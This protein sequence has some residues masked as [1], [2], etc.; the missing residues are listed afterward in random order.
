LLHVTATFAVAAT[1][2]P[3]KGRNGEL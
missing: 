1:Q 2:G 3:G